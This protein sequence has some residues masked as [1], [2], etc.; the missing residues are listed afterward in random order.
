MPIN[1]ITQYSKLTTSEAAWVQQG[2]GLIYA[3][4][5]ILV[6]DG[7]GLLQALAVGT[8]DH[9]LTADSTETL[10]IKWSSGGA[11]ANDKVGIDAGATAGYLGAASNDGVLRIDATL[12]YADGGDYITLSL[13]STLKTNYDAAYSHVSS[14]GT[15]HTYI[16]QDL[17]TSASP[18]FAGLSVSDGNITNVGDIA[19]DSISSDA[20]TSINVVLGSDAGDDFTI[21]TDKLIVEGDTGNIEIQN[22]LAIGVNAH[23]TVDVS[24]VTKDIQLG[25]HGDDV[26]NELDIYADRCSDDKFSCLFLARSRGTHASPTQVA[27]DDVL[28]CLAFLGWDGTDND[29]NMGAS[30][31]ARVNGTPGQNDLPTELVF[32][33]TADGETAVTERLAIGADGKSTF[34]YNILCSNAAG[35]TIVNEAATSTNPT[36][37]PNRADIDTGVGWNTT[38]AVSLIAGGAEMFG[39]FEKGTSGNTMV[40]R[41]GTLTSGG[42]DDRAL[43]VEATLNDSGAAGGSDLFNLIKGNVTAT[44]V[45]GWDTVNLIDLQVSTTSKFKVDN[46][47]NLTIGGDIGLTGTRITKGWFTNLEVTNDITING[48]ALAS[49]YQPLDTAL[50]N[51]S[52]LSYVSASFIK[53]TA[54]DT[55]AV[56]TLAETFGDLSGV[57][58]ADFS[59]NTHKITAV[60][61]P[62]ADQDAATKKYV[63]DNSINNVSEDTTPE[64]GGEMDCGAHSIGFTQQTATGDGT[65]T[66]DWKLGNKFQFTFGAQND[67]FTFTAPSNPCNILLILIQDG[68]GSRTATW[69]ATVKWPGGTAPT[70]TTDAS[71]VDI[72]SFYYNGTSYYGVSSLDFS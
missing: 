41:G 70:L 63:D 27:D 21:N 2:T 69:P 16:D 22:D 6:S 33:T 71:A 3:K 1:P 37:I 49:T 25:V 54:N 31:K 20:G 42:V 34:N 40:V 56:R 62:T 13:D 55:Y 58:A 59:M 51:I 48:T 30:I 15:D 8:N 47:G 12:G 72:V 65:T 28:G 4:G 38:D 64:L 60:V 14:D 36:I 11:S 24:G 57:A 29:L 7:A 68:T 35:P 26:L 43:Q 9:V 18:T 44:N 46:S 66:I 17:Q 45:T 5:T 53:L 61:D 23:Q 19:L 67:T 10:G 52:A 39:A 50:T 32:S